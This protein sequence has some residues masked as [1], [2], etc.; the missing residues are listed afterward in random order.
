DARRNNQGLRLPMNI[1]LVGNGG[2]EHA[3]AWRLRRSDSVGEILCPGGNPGIAQIARTIALPTGGNGGWVELARAEKADL[4][5]I[6]PEAPLAAGL[7]DD[8]RAAGLPV[9]GPNR[10]GA[11]IESSKAWSKEMMA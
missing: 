8:L 6:G 4:V 1:M 11:R 2:R 3:L 5:V 9:F 7:A 10:D